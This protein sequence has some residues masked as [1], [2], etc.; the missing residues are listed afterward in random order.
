MRNYVVPLEYHVVPMANTR[1]KSTTPRRRGLP[2]GPQGLPRAVV[3]ASQRERLLYAITEA[4]AV[5]GYAAVTL[6]D[7]VERASVSRRTFYEHFANK[8]QCFLAA[9]D[10]GAK[11]LLERVVAAHGEADD[12]VERGRRAIRAYLTAFAEEP[13]YARATMVEILGAGPMALARRREINLRYAKL[14]QDLHRQA[15]QDV[16]NLPGLPEPIFSAMVAGVDGLV[17]GYI[18]QGRTTE[19]PILEDVVL[20]LALALLADHETAANAITNR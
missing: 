1:A 11:A 19:L 5:K 10:A 20:Y 2:P 8:E 3:S 15:R 16:P 6:T 4:V 18:E 17:C 12:W 14:L 9:Y 13:D 7:V